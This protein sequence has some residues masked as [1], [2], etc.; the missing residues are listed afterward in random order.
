MQLPK[1]SKYK[2]VDKICIACGQRHN[3]TIRGKKLCNACGA[4]GNMLKIYK[5]GKEEFIYPEKI[6]QLEILDVTN[7]EEKAA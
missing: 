4:F 5:Y 1:V 3:E 7:P 2:M 6:S